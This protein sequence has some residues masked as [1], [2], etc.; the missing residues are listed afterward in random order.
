MHRL[1][2]VHASLKQFY[3]IGMLFLRVPS[4][5]HGNILSFKLELG[6]ISLM[7]TTPG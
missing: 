6:Q 3:N 1:I 5:D 2:Y 7:L 4:T